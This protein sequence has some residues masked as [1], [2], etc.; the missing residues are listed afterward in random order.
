MS[1]ALGVP[2]LGPPRPILAPWI[3]DGAE[4]EGG[5]QGRSAEATFKT[6]GLTH[7]KSLVLD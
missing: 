1:V 2:P 3:V 7:W 4:A 5:M 6:N